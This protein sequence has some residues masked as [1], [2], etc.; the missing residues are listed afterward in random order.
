MGNA[1]DDASRSTAG[2][3]L[4]LTVG[5]GLTQP[6]GRR[7]EFSP[8]TSVHEF[9]VWMKGPEASGSESWYALGEYEDD[10]RH[11]ERWR[12]A[13]GIGTDIDNLDADGKK[14]PISRQVLQRAVEGL[15]IGN[16]LHATPHGL[17]LVALL[18]RRVVDK[19]TWAR[20]ATTFGRAVEERL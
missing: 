17:R 10:H 5:A 18:D 8:E 14:A 13:S 15:D 20:A 16:I 9:A 7:M 6:K 1:T 2:E 12:S 11:G 4:R 3:V 19:S